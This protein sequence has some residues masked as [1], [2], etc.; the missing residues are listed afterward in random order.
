V[1][2]EEDMTISMANKEFEKLS[3]YSREEVEGKM[4]WTEFIVKED[5]EN[6]QAYHVKRR[7]NGEKVPTEYEFSFVGR[8]RNINNIDVKVALIPGTKRSI[9]SLLD[10]TERKQSEKVLQASEK[11]YRLLADNVSDVIWTMDMDLQPTYT[12]PSTKK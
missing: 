6:L 2:I 10:I 8:Q 7:E 5:L 3:G 11:K 12:S 9:A 1:I 4:K